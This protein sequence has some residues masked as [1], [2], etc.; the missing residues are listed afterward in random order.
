M[1]R[2]LVETATDGGNLHIYRNRYDN[3]DRLR[4]KRYPSGVEVRYGYD[5]V[6][7]LTTIASG[8]PDPNDP[9]PLDIEQF[10]LPIAAYKYKLDQTG[11]RVAL[12]IS[13]NGNPARQYAWEYDGV[14]PRRP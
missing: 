3:K 10:R 9:A 4:E 13:R 12:D 1:R 11:R 7:R 2:L 14:S 6:G 8:I 5:A